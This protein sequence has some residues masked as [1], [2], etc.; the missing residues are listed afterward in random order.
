MAGS[1]TPLERPTAVAR[2]IGFDERLKEIDMFFQG[3]DRVHQT[4]RR[5]V[6]KLD[7][8][9]IPYAVV[10]GM[11]VNAHHHERTTHDVD[12]LLTAEGFTEFTRQFV[13]SDFER[14]PGRPRR[15]RDPTNEVTFDILVT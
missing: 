13:P 11:A 1:R 3:T 6:E 10:G 5:V 7:A 2:A 12:F 14:V 15:F 9:N 8:S 4:M